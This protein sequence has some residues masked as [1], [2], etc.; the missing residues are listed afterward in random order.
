MTVTE[1]ILLGY[2]SGLRHML[3]PKGTD[4]KSL[5]RLQIDSSILMAVHSL[6][7]VT[8]ASIGENLPVAIRSAILL[9]VDSIS[10][11]DSSS[12]SIL[13]PRYEPKY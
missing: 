6:Q 4:D 5:W 13:S 2:F 1:G 8:I 9:A 11:I 7:N 12:L 3:Q 10:G